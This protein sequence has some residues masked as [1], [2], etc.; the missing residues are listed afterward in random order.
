MSPAEELQALD[1]RAYKP[2]PEVLQAIGGVS[3]IMAVAPQGAGKTT[4]MN[5]AIRQSELRLVIGDT[6]RPP[7]PGEKH[8]IHNYHR[9]LADMLEDVRAHR[10]VQ[11]A[12]TPDHATLYATKPE[13][14]YPEGIGTK[15]VYAHAV[16][17]F[18]ALPF[19]AVYAAF[20]V[21][22]S[23]DDWLNSFNANTQE[24]PEEIRRHRWQEARQSYEFA[25]GDEQMRFVLNDTIAAAAQRFLQVARGQTPSDETFARKTAEQ[26]LVKLNKQVAL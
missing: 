4:V 23:F 17:Q 19:K 6:S 22:A 21:R 14:Y 3:L 13:H 15:E 9:D 18:R 25:L 7:R 11:I 2:A 1:Q 20:V 5:E 10:Y 24:M 16:E 26:N 8:G 12:I